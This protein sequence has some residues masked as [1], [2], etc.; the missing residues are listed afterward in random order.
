MLPGSGN[1]AAS[2]CFLSEIRP[3]IV[4][5]FYSVF[6][7]ASG[8]SFPKTFH[9][10]SAR[11]QMKVRAA[12]NGSRAVVDGFAFADAHQN[13]VR[14]SIFLTLD[15]VIRWW[16]PAEFRIFWKAST[17]SLLNL[18]SPRADHDPE[19]QYKN[20]PCRKFLSKHLRVF[21]GFFV[22]FLLQ[23][24]TDRA[25]SDPPKARS[26]RRFVPLKV[27]DQCAGDDTSL[28]YRLSTP[29]KP[30]CNSLPD[31]SPAEPDYK[32]GVRRLSNRASRS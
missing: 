8:N 24:M 27:P 23:K 13:F 7:S 30:N 6:V 22:I 21:A 29:D 2:N 5:Q 28:R 11:T 15:N 16:R 14:Q 26:N 10:S 19:F 18:F 31:F 3:D 4:R 25:G 17:K 1:S 9:I 12:Q 32:M 20:F